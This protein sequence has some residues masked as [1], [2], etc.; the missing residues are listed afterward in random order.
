MAALIPFILL[1]RHLDD[2][3]RDSAPL[4]STYTLY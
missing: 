1:L 3:Q 2:E 4:A